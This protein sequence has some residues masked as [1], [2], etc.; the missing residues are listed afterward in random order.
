ML[1]IVLFGIYYLIPWIH[2]YDIYDISGKECEVLT[3]NLILCAGYNVSS[4]LHYNTYTPTGVY[5][6]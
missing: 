3:L 6:R 5:V 4:M 2:S 1:S